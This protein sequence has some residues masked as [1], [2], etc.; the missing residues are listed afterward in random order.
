MSV[1][2]YFGRDVELSDPANEAQPVV[3]SDT[4]DLPRV[5]RSLYVGTAGNIVMQGG[6]DDAP[7]T[8]K[9]VPAGSFLPFRAKR[10]MA[11]GTTAA[12]ILAL[13]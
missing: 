4:A 6:D 2:K 5:T 1:D 12:D 3:P 7:R 11:T 13:Y 8:W 9:N 10:I